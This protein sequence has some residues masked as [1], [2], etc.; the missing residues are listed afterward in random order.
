M[1][2]CPID[3]IDLY[4]FPWTLADNA[5]SWLEPTSECNLKCDGCYRENRRGSHKSLAEVKRELD[6]FQTRRRSDCISIA[7]GDPLLYPDIVP[8][9]AEIKRR[10][11]KPILN[12]NGHALTEPLLRE[13]KRAG[14]FGFTFHVDSGQGRPG[15]W[16]GCNE[17]E[18]NG[19]RLEYASMVARVGGITCSFNATIY[20]ENLQYVPGMLDWAQRHIDIV[21]TMV[22]ICFRHIVPEMP[23]K[24]LA[25]DR[26]VRREQVLYHS[27]RSRIITIGSRE[28][29]AKVRQ[30]VDPRWQPSAY[31]NGTADP[32][33]LKWLLTQ[34]IGNRK[35]V[36]GYTGPRFAELAMSLYHLRTGRYLSY[37][38]AENTRHGRTAML[39][40]A[41]LD[42]HSRRALRRWLTAA[43]HNPLR[44]FERSHIQAVMFIQPVDFMPDGMQSMC[45]GCPDITVHDGRLV[46]SCRLEELK[47]FGHFLGTVPVAETLAGQGAAPGESAT[48]RD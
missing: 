12:T 32:T 8:L 47:E 22:F 25:G 13:L 30:E 21:Q 15:R 4:R 37:V 7:G 36:Y 33:A 10:G 11:W 18:L 35:R 34:R 9:V 3:A 41:L 38:S 29:L 24:W 17:L 42:P 40:F 31:L 28:L 14:L 26:E 19:L 20:Q 43:L 6:V 23:F 44:L 39:L 45:D 27:D 2:T 48:T 16:Q 5:I 1:S 46:W